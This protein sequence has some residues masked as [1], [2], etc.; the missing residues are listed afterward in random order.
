MSRLKAS[1]LNQDY[2]ELKNFNVRRENLELDYDDGVEQRR[3]ERA[4]K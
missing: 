4:R 1:F 3:K 2:Q